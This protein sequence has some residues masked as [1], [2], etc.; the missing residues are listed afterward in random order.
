M[1]YRYRGKRYRISTGTTKKMVAE[2]M[3][4]A[5]EGDI[6]Q[7]KMPSVCFQKYTFD[8]LAADLVTDYQVNNRKS[9]NKIHIMLRK[10]L[11][12]YFGGRPVAEI[13][14]SSIS[15]YV[16]LRL[17][18]GAKNGTINRELTALK[19]M[20]NL[21]AKQTP[22]KVDRVPVITMLKEDNVRTGFFEVDE[23]KRLMEQLPEFLKG[24]AL[25]AYRS[26]WRIKEITR[27]TWDR[28]DM[29]SGSVRLDPKQTKSGK[30]RVFHLDQELTALFRDRL[31]KR[32]LGCS[33]VFHRDTLEIKNYYPVWRKA[34]DEAGLKGRV[35]HDFRRTA[36]RNMIRAGVSERVAM[37]ISGHQT[38]AIF[39]RYNVVNEDD[40]R[41]ATELLSAYQ[42]KAGS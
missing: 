38:R 30:G 19:R 11:T 3:L 18:Q 32:K 17:D 8:E 5:Q 22:P 27:L 25:F 41:K 1:D 2:Q 29:K 34:C 33:F 39:D 40:L 37:I 16:R 15:R 10:H 36:I 9:E 14:S 7:G 12:P 4:K 26:G 31:S 28:V 35:F 24:P 13:T 21:G 20:L 23:F 6:A 42:T